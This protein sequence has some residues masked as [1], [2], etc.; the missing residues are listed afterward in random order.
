[1]FGNERKKNF[2]VLNDFFR[3][4]FV[5]TDYF[6]PRKLYFQTMDLDPGV[7]ASTFREG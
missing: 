1:M 3:L 2:H 7:L 6:W 4:F 5:L